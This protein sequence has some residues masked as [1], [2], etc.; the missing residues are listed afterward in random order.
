MLKSD[1]KVVMKTARDIFSGFTFSRVEIVTVFPAR[2]TIESMNKMM[3]KSLVKICKK[4][5][6]IMINTL[7]ND[8]HIINFT[9]NAMDINFTSKPFLLTTFSI[10]IPTINI[11]KIA[12]VPFK[13]EK[14]S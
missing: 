1:I 10:P 5:L 12:K 7:T 3:Y 11:P 2:G 4:I 8:G 14:K 13:Y 6:S 9:N